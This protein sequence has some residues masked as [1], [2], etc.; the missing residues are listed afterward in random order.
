MP[1]LSNPTLLKS[2]GPSERRTSGYSVF[3]W[4]EYTTVPLATCLVSKPMTRQAENEG[5]V[6]QSKTHL[7]PRISTE[8]E[9]AGHHL[10]QSEVRRPENLILYQI[11]VRSYT[12]PTS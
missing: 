4:S 5:H 8:A 7:R 11:P 6:I 12:P 2:L 1:L 9:E 10:I 3:G